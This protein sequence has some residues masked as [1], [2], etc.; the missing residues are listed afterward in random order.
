MTEV[1]AYM[2]SA[3]TAPIPVS[4]GTPLPVTLASGG[5]DSLGAGATDATTQRTTAGGSAYV[6]VATATT[7]QVKSGT[8][9]LRR[10]TVN[11]KGTV[12][13]A[14]SIYDATSGTSNPIAII[15]SLNLSGTFSF[16]LAF[17]TGLRVIT[18][19]TVAPD[20]TVVYD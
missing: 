8:G 4:V 18:T 12:A 7:T 20:I 9:V 1:A 15:D 19:G 2:N 3:G 10:V 11:T 16:D 5:G 6:H 14:I 13:S 17:A